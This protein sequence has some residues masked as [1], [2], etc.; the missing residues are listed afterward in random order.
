[1]SR[2]FRVSLVMLLCVLCGFF[3]KKVGQLTRE[4]RI[5]S[6]ETHQPLPP[7]E[8][9]PPSFLPISEPY[10]AFRETTILQDEAYTY[11]LNLSQH[12][13]EFAYLQ[14]YTCRLL[15]SKEG[16]C[17]T[18]HGD[19]LLV[20]AMKSHATFGDRRAVQRANWAYERLMYNYIVKPL[21]LLGTVTDGKLMSMVL[22]EEEDFQDILMWDF[23]ESHHNLALKERCFLE[24]LYH[25]CKEAAFIFKGDDDEFLNPSAMVRYVQKTP[26]VTRTIHGN[27]QRHLSVDRQGRNQVSVE[28]LSAARLPLFPSGG[29]YIMPGQVIPALYR[30][31]LRLPVF[32]L[33][34]VYLGF[35]ALAAGVPFRHDGR[36]H[37]FSVREDL[38]MFREAI[39]VHGFLAKNLQ[40]LWVRMRKPISCDAIA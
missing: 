32:P 28:L 22:K 16:F 27:I 15:T 19:P 18:N 25:H 2:A 8:P 38:C 23:T 33:D 40:N 37:S 1:M 5:S 13:K 12:L 39:M 14:N 34:D 10:P 3:Y 9:P 17:Q 20:V 24:W 29:G 30:A 7:K 31:S 35:L 36:F 4:P 26:N 21:F 6:N 11:T